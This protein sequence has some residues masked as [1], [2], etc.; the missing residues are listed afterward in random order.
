L[1]ATLVPDLTLPASATDPVLPFA[2]ATTSVI[3]TFCG[4]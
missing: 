2:P 4:V 3:R 1:F